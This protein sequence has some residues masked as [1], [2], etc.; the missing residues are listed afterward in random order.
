MRTVDAYSDLVRMGK[1]ILTTDDASVRLRMSPSGTTRVLT[2][3]AAAG[4]ARRIF[5]GLWTIDLKLDP[6]TIPE[7]LTVPF[8]AYISFQS[9]LYLHGLISQIPQVTYVA[10]LSPTRRVKTSMG[11][12]SIHR[13]APEYF[14]GYRTAADSG[15]RLATPEK[16]LMDVLYLGSAR[17]RLFASLPELTLPKDFRVKEAR[18]WVDR[19][20]DPS[21]R[22]MVRSRLDEILSKQGL[23]RLGAG[24]RSTSRSQNMPERSRGRKRLV[25]KRRT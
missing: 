22:T 12:Y 20:R 10:S 21:R 19:I 18:L 15:V 1:P 25:A 11:T 4:L 16:A 9:A 24:H 13:L 23:G 3:L 17:S 14:G 7:H 8:A 2:R 6:L 5:R